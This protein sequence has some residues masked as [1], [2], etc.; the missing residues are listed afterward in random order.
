[1]QWLERFPHGLEFQCCEKL[2]PTSQYA[3]RK[4]AQEWAKERAEERKIKDFVAVL[5]NDPTP[6]YQTHINVTTT[7]TIRECIEALGET[8]WST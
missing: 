3:A 2:S 8:Q 7:A 5:Y 4:V 6:R 1:M